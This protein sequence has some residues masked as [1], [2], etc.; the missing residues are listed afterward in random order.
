MIHD[1]QEG[2]SLQVDALC[3]DVSALDE[4]LAAALIP[5]TFESHGQPLVGRMLVAQGAGTHPTI[6]LLHGF[7]GHDQNGDLMQ[8]F[9]RAGWNVMTFHYRG[10]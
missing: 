3:H 4:E 8:S 10:A 7:P 9:R 5:L 1:E 2:S 6:L